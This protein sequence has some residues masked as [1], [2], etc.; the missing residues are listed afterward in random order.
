LLTT[1][2]IGVRNS[3]TNG[4]RLAECGEVSEDVSSSGPTSANGLLSGSDHRW[5]ESTG[6][7]ET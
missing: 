1:L 3:L 4:P 2:D 7:S 5:I 6:L